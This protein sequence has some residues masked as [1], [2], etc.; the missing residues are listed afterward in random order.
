MPKKIKSAVKRFGTRYGRTI[1]EKVAK[2]EDKLRGKHKCPYCSALK[3]KRIAAGI[4]AC[5]KCKSKF[6]GAAYAV[7]RN[8]KEREVEESA[9]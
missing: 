6:T 3:A 4:W 7:K 8:I 5:K 2:I 1:R 9:D